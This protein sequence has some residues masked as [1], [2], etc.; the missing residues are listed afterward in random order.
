MSQNT[1][2]AIDTL[3]VSQ[4]LKGLPA[5]QAWGLLVVVIG[6]VAGAFTLGYKLQLSATEVQLEKKALEVESFRGLQ[7][8]ERFLSL[9]LRYLIADNEAISQ[10]TSDNSR[11]AGKAVTDLVIYVDVLVRE[12]DATPGDVR[13][14][15]GGAMTSITF[16]YD[17][18]VWK[19]PAE[20]SDLMTETL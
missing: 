10:P 3:T 5:R 15:K 19:L 6:F 14:G 17:G 16:G 20:V 11:N 1:E 12:G 4:I 2:V 8:K 7:A 9:Y 18:T 13:I